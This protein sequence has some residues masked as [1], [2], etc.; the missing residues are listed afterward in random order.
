M[1]QFGSL[2]KAMERMLIKLT[3]AI[4]QHTYGRYFLS[5]NLNLIR[6]D[7]FH[8]EILALGVDW[9]MSTAPSH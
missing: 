3:T 1:D 7:C 4:D 6:C 8:N 9:F 2:K 5:S